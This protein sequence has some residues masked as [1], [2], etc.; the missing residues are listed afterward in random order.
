[1]VLMFGGRHHRI[2]TQTD[3]QA[4]VAVSEGLI[5]ADTRYVTAS[6]GGFIVKVDVEGRAFFGYGN[7]ITQPRQQCGADGELMLIGAG[8]VEFSFLGHLPDAKTAFQAKPFVERFREQVILGTHPHVVVVEQVRLV[9]AA[10]V[11]CGK[12]ALDARANAQP[13]PVSGRCVEPGRECVALVAAKAPTVVDGF[14]L[15]Q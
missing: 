4:D 5:F 7:R 9:V 6:A 11:G 10:V 3:V 13:F 15:A 12:E 8:S 14:L 2:R 1:M